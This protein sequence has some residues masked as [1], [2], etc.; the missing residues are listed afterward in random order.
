MVTTQWPPDVTTVGRKKP[1]RFILIWLPGVTRRKQI[2]DRFRFTNLD[3]TFVVE[4]ERLNGCPTNP[5]QPNDSMVIPAEVLVPFVATGMK[6]RNR[7]QILGTTEV[8]DGP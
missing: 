5:S 3:S 2:E 8:G 1:I 4:L 7:L 6:K